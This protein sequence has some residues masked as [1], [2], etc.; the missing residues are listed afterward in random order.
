VFELLTCARTAHPSRVLAPM[1]LACAIIAAPIAT[2][3]T[4]ARRALAMAG[5][6]RAVARVSSRPIVGTARNSRTVARR[7]AVRCAAGDGETG[8]FVP[9]TTPDRIG[10]AAAWVALGSTAAFIAPTG[11]SAFDMDL[12]TGLISAPFSGTTNPIF[13]ALFNSLG[14]V[15]AVYAALL[16][17]GGKGQPRLAPTLPIAASFALGFFALGPYLILREPRDFV[18]SVARKDLGWATRT[19]FE[20][21]IFALFN[22][23]FAAFLIGYGA[24]HADQAAV[25]GFKTLWAEQSA[26]CCVSSCD[27]LVLSL[28]VYGAVAEDQKR[29]GVFS[30]AKAAAFAAVPVL[31]PCLWLVVRPELE[32]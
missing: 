17:P 21:K 13:E 5:S 19:I 8:A 3:P 24:S 6:T 1:S 20:S 27:L 30:V 25:E 29:R 22:A 4:R 7:K 18:G 9:W 10:L 28:A 14:V 2:A 31:G 32:D 11:T 23:A 12:I 26:L 16:L 15:P